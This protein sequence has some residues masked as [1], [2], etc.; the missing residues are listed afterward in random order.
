MCPSAVGRFTLSDDTALR[1]L[2]CRRTTWPEGNGGRRTKPDLRQ[3]D[4]VV[5]R[6][7]ARFLFEFTLNSRNRPARL[8][9]R[10]GCGNPVHRLPWTFSVEF[11]CRPRAGM[12]SEKDTIRRQSTSTGRRPSILF[13]LVDRPFA[14]PLR[15]PRYRTPLERAIHTECV[16]KRGIN[17]CLC[18]F[19]TH[20]GGWVAWRGTC[21]PQT[22]LT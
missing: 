16:T 9:A 4:V 18:A 7:S 21:I 11:G 13:Y 22:Q 2:T 10:G 12:P 17:P 8:C 20:N 15:M 1:T 6:Q 3:R 5:G 14:V 19:L